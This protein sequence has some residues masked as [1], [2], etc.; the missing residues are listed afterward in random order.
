MHPLGIVGMRGEPCLDIAATLCRQLVVDE[1]V[2]LVFGHG[3]IR[4]GHCRG[5]CP[6]PVEK[7]LIIKH[8]AH[9]LF[10]T[11]Q[12]WPLALENCFHMSPGSRKPGH[13]GADRYALN[14]G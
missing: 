3:N 12:R 10:Y 7:Y 14:L 11:A 2:K 4:V 6:I 1:S 13:Y 9:R 8:V 5:L